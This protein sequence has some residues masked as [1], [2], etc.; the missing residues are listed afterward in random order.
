MNSCP[1][2][3]DQLGDTMRKRTTPIPVPPDVAVTVFDILRG[4]LFVPCGI[5]GAHVIFGS[6]M[7]REYFFAA[8][9]DFARVSP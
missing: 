1:P 6:Y 7:D 2:Q 3:A 8:L 9:N 5:L 4:S